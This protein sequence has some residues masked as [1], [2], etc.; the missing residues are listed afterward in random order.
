MNIELI[1]HATLW[2]EYHG[3]TI[4]VDPMFGD[5]G[6]YPPIQGSTNDRRNPLTPLPMSIESIS[7]PD[8][9]VVTHVHNDHW[10]P[11][12]V[13]A[14]PKHTLILCQPENE[15]V[16]LNQGQNPARHLVR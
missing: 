16:F 5:V 1:R 6:A 13:Q 15:K 9:I 11:A 7:N 3:Q 2:I 12:A 4:L 10:D 14:L 8:V